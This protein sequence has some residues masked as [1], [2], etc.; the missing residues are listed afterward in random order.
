M[1]RPFE[2]VELDS[3][4]VLIRRD[5]DVERISHYRVVTAP[6]LL[7]TEPWYKPLLLSERKSTVPSLT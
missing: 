7:E 4:T 1:S 6:I 5:D 2:I 3:E